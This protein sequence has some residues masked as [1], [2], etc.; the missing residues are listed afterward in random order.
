MQ[1]ITS[2]EK[3]R[4]LSDSVKRSKIVW[5]VPIA[6]I[7]LTIFISKTFHVQV[8]FAH[9]DLGTTAIGVMIV[10]CLAAITYYSSVTAATKRLLAN[11]CYASVEPRLQSGLFWHRLIG[12]LSSEY[13]RD[14]IDLV[15][16]SR[17]L[18][19]FERARE[20]GEQA[21]LVIE[22]RANQPV[23]TATTA[24][25]A[26]LLHV[27]QKNVKR[28]CVLLRAQL[29]F[30][31]G[32]CDYARRKRTDAERQLKQC[33]DLC[34][35]LF[36]EHE[37]ELCSPQQKNAAAGDSAVLAAVTMRSAAQDMLTVLDT[38]FHAYELTERIHAETDAVIGEESNASARRE[39]LAKRG[40][41]LLDEGLVSDEWLRNQLRF[42]C[43]FYA[44]DYAGLIRA[45]DAV[46]SEPK[47]ETALAHQLYVMRGETHNRLGHLDAAVDDATRA[48]E[49][50]PDSATA[51]FNRAEVYRKQRRHDLAQA[52][53][54]RAASLG[55]QL[56][57]LTV[58]G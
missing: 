26:E 14:L 10:G 39:R 46:L 24:K 23:P 15:R 33:V 45:L 52:D 57:Q 17:E 27:A 3:K 31:L 53:L 49:Y 44:K 47:L 51:L 16:V 29:L 18:R 41:R 1:A 58:D 40:L 55:A 13:I 5:G 54:D 4:R 28:D 8:P 37:Q 32:A 48:L 30:E 35:Q 21:L 34:E 25:N 7:F 43:L 22:H 50:A 19:K 9:L 2:T 11:C 20:Y 36:T 56:P 38:A 42:L 12:P 6:I